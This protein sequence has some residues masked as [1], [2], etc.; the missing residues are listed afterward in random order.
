MAT[1]VW[2]RADSRIRP[3]SSSL[4]CFKRY[5]FRFHFAQSGSFE[6]GN[7]RFQALQFLF[8]HLQLRL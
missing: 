6:G 5:A 8:H 3:A 4:A 1:F 2:L 7:F